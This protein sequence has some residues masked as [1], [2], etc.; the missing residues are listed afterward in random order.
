MRA[1]LISLMLI[2]GAGQAQSFSSLEER[3][4]AAEFREAGLDQLSPEQLAKLNEW[5]RNK[6]PSTLESGSAAPAPVAS[7]SEAGFENRGGKREPIYTR[8]SGSFEGWSG[9]TKFVL[10][11]GQVWQQV[12][13]DV[14]R[15]SLEGPAVE[16][17]P[18]LLGAWVLQVEGSNRITAVK[19]IK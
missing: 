11:N 16:I 17:R 14:W 1:L 15:T 9:R 10:D 2:A 13:G 8:I 3:M 4:S 7:S 5:L 6:A 19:R 12:D 18:K